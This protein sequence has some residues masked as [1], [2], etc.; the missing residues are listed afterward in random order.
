MKTKKNQFK[1]QA[2]GHNFQTWLKQPIREPYSKPWAYR[3]S[4]L[5]HQ[6]CSSDLYIKISRYIALIMIIQWIMEQMS[7]LCLNEQNWKRK[8]KQFLVLK[9]FS[10]SGLGHK[11]ELLKSRTFVRSNFFHL[12]FF[13]SY[14]RR[15]ATE[16]AGHSF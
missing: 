4:P 9:F 12:I 6:S 5:E 1:I 3:Q 14:R 13:S 16:M 7:H 10:F 11:F 8:W 15:W 2:L